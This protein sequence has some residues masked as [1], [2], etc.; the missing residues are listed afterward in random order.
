MDR[1]NTT[2]NGQLQVQKRGFSIRGI[3]FNIKLKLHRVYL[4]CHIVKIN[5]I[6][7]TNIIQISGCSV[8]S[9][10]YIS[11][12]IIRKRHHKIDLITKKISATRGTQLVHIGIPTVC[13]YNLISNRMKMLPNKKVSASH[14][15]WQD[16]AWYFFGCS[17][18]K[19]RVS[20]D[21]C[22]VRR[23]LSLEGNF[24]MIDMF[25]FNLIIS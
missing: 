13:L 18:M 14:T 1:N 24:N 12:L 8:R 10:N 2:S 6:Y 25:I 4:T 16:H 9:V 15:F 7:I 23:D 21:T 5:I 20:V 19:E 11:Q 17:E 3:G 22:K